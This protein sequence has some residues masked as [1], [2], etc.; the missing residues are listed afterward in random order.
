MTVEHTAATQRE[1]VVAGLGAYVIWGLVPVFFKQFHDVPALEIIAHRVVWSLVFMGAVLAIGRG[2]AQARDTFQ[3]PRRLARVA[4]GA[5]FV[6]ANWLVFVYAINTGRILATSLG[7]F[8][9]PMV[10]VAL[11]VLVLGEQ[12]RRLQWVAVG[13][14]CLGVIAETVHAGELPWIS[15]LLAATFGIYGLL[16]KR[17]PLDAASGLFL[18]TACVLPVAL[19]YLLWLEHS[20]DGHFMQSPV[21]AGLLV[22]SGAVTALPLLL[23]AISARRL[24][25]NMM[26]FMQYLAP[27]ISALIAVFAYGEAFD[28][29][30]AA[31]F[32]AIWLGI[33]VYSVDVWRHSRPASATSP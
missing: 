10:S 28:A 19:G 9:L 16:R 25:L 8:I 32:G 3:S 27:T 2:F 30:R 21:N 12:L 22:A 13:F 7:Y 31:A 15:L 6:S 26:G 11:G 17:L 29:P 4:L 1:G 5:L 23:F 14:A 18:A 33:A 20:G 24:P